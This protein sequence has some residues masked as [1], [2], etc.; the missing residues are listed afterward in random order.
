MAT[1]FLDSCSHSGVGAAAIPVSRKWT[2]FNDA[3]YQNAS[4]GAPV[5]R[6]GQTVLA[7]VTGGLVSRS[8]SY[9]TQ[10]TVGVRYYIPTA[11]S[12]G[13]IITFGTGGQ[14]LCSLNIESDRSISIYTYPSLIKI[15]NSGTQGFF[16]TTDVFHYFEMTVTLGGGNPIGVT[17]SVDIDSTQWAVNASGPTGVIATDTLVGT[18][19]MN[20]ITISAPQGNVTAY[21]C[22]IYVFNGLTTDINGN[23]TA[24]TGMTGDVSIDALIPIADKTP[25]QWSIFPSGSPSSFSLI[26]EIPPDDD[27]TYIFSSSLGQVSMFQFQQLVGFLGTI[28]SAQL[29]L[30]VKKDAEGARAITGVVGNTPVNNLFGSSSQLY[31]YYDYFLYPLDSDNGT[32]WTPSVYNAEVFGIKLVS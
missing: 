22:D 17:V 11:S 24:N 19:S 9:Q 25:L 5:D 7:I 2:V 3:S 29:C 32:Q 18:T 23:V 12:S 27:T 8:C 16:V 28:F 31:D 6:A 26:D 20:Q 4:T 10:R 14:E 1:D 30:Y 21:A 13:P 15:Y